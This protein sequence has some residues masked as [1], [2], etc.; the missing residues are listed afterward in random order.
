MLDDSSNDK[1]RC[2][3]PCPTRPP[4]QCR[5][6]SQRRSEEAFFDSGVQSGVLCGLGHPQDLPIS[7]VRPTKELVAGSLLW[8]LSPGL[9][10]RQRI[11]HSA[12]QESKP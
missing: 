6:G 8:K 10:S 4:G 9:G 11:N 2:Q 7:A 1:Q 5:Y 3:E 12:A